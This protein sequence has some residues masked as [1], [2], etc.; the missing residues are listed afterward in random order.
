[1]L[2]GVHYFK[3]H[4]WSIIR[5]SAGRPIKS[6]ET[7]LPERKYTPVLDQV[8]LHKGVSHLSESRIERSRQLQEK[9][10]DFVKRIINEETGYQTKARR[11]AARSNRE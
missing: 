7:S 6:Q 1:M 4:L 8:R 11:Q 3:E 5:Q 9:C 2:H 10:N